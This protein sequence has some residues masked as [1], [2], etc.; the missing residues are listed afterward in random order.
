MRLLARRTRFEFPGLGV[1]SHCPVHIYGD[2]KK[3]QLVV[4]F[5]HTWESG[6]GSPI[7]NA[8]ENAATKLYSQM[9]RPVSV[10]FFVRV[11][12]CPHVPCG[13]PQPYYSEVVHSVE[14]GGSIAVD[15]FRHDLTLQEGNRLF[16]L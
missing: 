5:V 4:L 8:F 9:N 15:G 13:V 12:K 10:R 11:E 14:P 1:K 3:R 16:N 7:F 6:C 2:D